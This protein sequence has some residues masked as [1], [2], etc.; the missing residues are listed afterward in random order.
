MKVKSILVSQPEPSAENN[1]YAALAAKHQ[2]RP[3]ARVVVG[4]VAVVVVPVALL[5]VC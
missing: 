5:F 2:A 4:V 3:E 1:P